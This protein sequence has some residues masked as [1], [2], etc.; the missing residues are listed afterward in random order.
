MT[1][2]KVTARRHILT[3]RYWVRLLSVFAFALA[4][5]LFLTPFLLGFISIWGVTHPPCNM[6]SDPG[7]FNPAF[8]LISFTSANGLQQ[9][10]YFI[11]GT[12]SATIINVPTYNLGRGAQLHYAQVFN[13]NGFN[14]LTFNGRSCTTQGWMSLGYQ[15]AEDVVAA[16]NYL[17][18]RSDIDPS[19]VGLHGFSSATATSIFAAARIPE[20]RS[21]SVEGGYHDYPAVLEWGRARNY[22]D[23]LYQVGFVSGYRLITGDDIHKLK[24]IDVLD[25]LAGRSLL[26]IY[27]STEVSL[28]GAREM[29]QR[30]QDARVD[31]QLWVVDGAGHGDYLFVA[32]DEFIRRVVSFHQATLLESNAA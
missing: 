15:E 10:G 6:G 19:R 26:L 24:P 18:T 5:A 14:V 3:R 22:F 8:E 4:F 12:N 2:Q 28:P 7:W 16:Y 11:P 23:A 32:G 9:D 1:A 25:Q 13:E 29:L 30:A 17:K 31:A 20:I 21:V 27:G